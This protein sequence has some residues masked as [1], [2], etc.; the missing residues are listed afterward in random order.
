MRDDRGSCKKTVEG[1]SGSIGVLQIDP[2]NKAIEGI[3]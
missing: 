3:E 2:H 1:R